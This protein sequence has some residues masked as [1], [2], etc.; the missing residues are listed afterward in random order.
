MRTA[1]WLCAALCVSSLPL[2]AQN[3]DVTGTWSGTY[4]LSEQRPCPHTSRN[5]ASASFLQSGSNVSGV[6]TLVDVDDE[7][8][9]APDCKVVRSFS[10]T[11]PI[12]GTVIGTSFTGTIGIPDSDSPTG[13]TDETFSSTVSGESMTINLSGVDASLVISINRTDKTAPSS[14]LSG[15]Y[16][17]SY[18][19]GFTACGKTPI[20]FGGAITGSLSQIGASLSGTLNATDIKNDRENQDGSCTVLTSPVPIPFLLQAT[21]SGN[22]VTGSFT[23]N[24]G[25]GEPF[26]IPFTA[27][28]SGNTISGRASGTGDDA[29]TF[30]NFTITKTGG[31]PTTP[32]QPVISSFNANP[33]SIQAGQSSTLS[34]AT[35]NATS[36]VIDN[37]VGNVA[38]S[39]SV[40]VTPG[41][42]TTYTLKATNS[43]GSAM[44]TTT[45]TVATQGTPRVV[46]SSL[47][48][49]LLQPA[50]QGGGAD[51]F[52][53]A[54]LGDGPTTLTFVPSGGF[55]TVSPTSATLAGG[56]ALT[57]SIAGIAQGGGIFN[58]NV[59]VNGAG[60]SGL[61]V[62]VQLLSTPPETQRVTAAPAVART[63]LSAP[64]GQQTTTGT[65]SFT[66]TGAGTLRALPAAD[67]PF[68]TPQSGAV[69][70]PP[71]ESR[72][73]SYTVDNNKRPDASSPLGG[74]LGKISL[75]FFTG[76]GAPTAFADP[77]PS[78]STS[79]VSVSV[80]HVVRPG[81]AG[82]GAPP[83]PSG[84]VALFVP[85]V[86]NKVTSTSD[87]LVSSRQITTALSDVRIY[88]QG[89]GASPQ[90]ASISQLLPNVSV[91][92]PG[93]V[94]NVF[95]STAAT[96]SAQI[97]TADITRLAVGAVRA[98]T[99]SPNGTYA[100]PLPVFRSDR[101]RTGGAQIVLSGLARNSA[102]KTDVVVQEVSGN[103]GTF[104]LD[105]VDAS[106]LSVSRRNGMSIASFE[107]VEVQ[108]ALP[109]NAVAARVIATGTS[110]LLN[111][112]ALVSDT[113]TGD[114]WLVTDPA[115]DGNSD[116]MIVPLL[117]AGAGSKTQLFLTSRQGDPLTLTLQT[118]STGGRHRAAGSAPGAVQT[119]SVTL[120]PR[121]SNTIDLS[122]ASVGFVRVMAS[123]AGSVSVA[124]R[125]TRSA[126]GGT[127]G[128]SLPPIAVANA[129]RNGQNKRF[130]GVEDSSAASRSNAVPA[131]FHSN[132]MLIET[133]NAPATVR[134]TVQ[135]ALSGS[136]LATAQGRVTRDF[137]IGASEFLVIN[138]L[139][140]QVI[141][142]SRDSI[143]D[144][145]NVL[146]DVD[147]VGGDGRVIPLMQSFDNGSGDMIVRPE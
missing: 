125:S 140:R 34:W 58:G 62:P 145:H 36:V 124:A 38:T 45:V 3:A 128:A 94:R 107:S 10:P 146:V 68:I 54:N 8:T 40:T 136:S 98:N 100:T 49:G 17:G 85:G 141:G 103:A 50:G 144:L 57:V 130:A 56:Q 84:Q 21:V 137:T 121:Q 77:P 142:P 127:F 29:D 16:S 75:T 39:G 129:L 72:T 112:Y 99:S 93:I 18:N 82:G 5:A 53:V 111:A 83:I 15:T 79:T 70:I 7:V 143:G 109:D 122:S 65:I 64:P 44:Q 89:G 120:Q 86:T 69:Q 41:A 80:A 97:R 102:T 52:S 73:I 33:P 25:D 51:S 117:S 23:A 24:D 95:S 59:T 113:T 133:A 43:A 138:D 67:V 139:A 14:A 96:A 110:S 31:G 6:T 131:T 114:A 22:A 20:T 116:E 87:L 55:F 90:T 11:L 9:P 76:S 32:G 74:A 61:V 101:G 1:R 71:G 48:R 47:P 92:L 105:F 132:L 123:P 35:Q 126:S 4:T 30:I 12:K 104:D 91:S 27:T 13:F 106:G 63:E 37:G 115:I 66:N 60:A 147:V 108:D 134:V 135:F 119:R 88:L 81:V 46:I 2:L 78:S 42:T 19:A 28:V 118:R 26:A